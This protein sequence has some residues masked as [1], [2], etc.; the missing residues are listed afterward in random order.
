M[1][2]QYTTQRTEMAEWSRALWCGTLGQ[3]S[4]PTNTSGYMICKYTNWKGS[5]AMLGT[6]K[7]AGVA[8]EV[9]PVKAG[10]KARIHPN[11]ETQGK[12]YQK[13]KT[14]LSV[15]PQKGLIF[16]KTFF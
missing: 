16:S 11:F 9:N 4:T 14:G 10:E 3:G 1:N 2:Y 5:A 12:W 7:F 13:F 15:A 6:K 8:P